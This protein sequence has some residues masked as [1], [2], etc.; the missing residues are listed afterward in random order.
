[1]ASLS[2]EP[3]AEEM[4]NSRGEGFKRI[5]RSRWTFLGLQVLDLFT[6]LYAFHAG[7]LEVNPLV[8]HLTVFFGRFRGVL[9]SKLMA[10]AI[11]MGV[12]RLLWVVNLIYIGIVG[13]NLITITFFALRWK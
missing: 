13:W 12:R 8:A 4:G 2:S 3:L 5:L 6:T 7:A 1:M 11:A 9:V 10:V